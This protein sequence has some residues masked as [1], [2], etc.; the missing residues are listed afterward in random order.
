MPIVEVSIL[1]INYQLSCNPNEEQKLID[2]AKSVHEKLENLSKSYPGV[3]NAKLMVL[4]SLIMEDAI[5]D[6]KTN[7]TQQVSGLDESAV[8]MAMD[9]ITGYVEELAKKIEKL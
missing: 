2:V 9:T 3:S 7:K 8:C 4:N 1:G 5:Q 6:L